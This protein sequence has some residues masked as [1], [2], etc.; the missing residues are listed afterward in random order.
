ETVADPG[1]LRRASL[2]GDA[3]LPGGNGAVPN[4]GRQSDRSP[5]LLRVAVQP[6]RAALRAAERR[7]VGKSRA[8]HGWPHLS[9]GRGPAAAGNS[10]AAEIPGHAGDVLI[11]VSG[12]AAA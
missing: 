8:R 7:T 11:L 10:M 1:D 5:G 12:A 6:D 2:C 9:L 3:R 4:G